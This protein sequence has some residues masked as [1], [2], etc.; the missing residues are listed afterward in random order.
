L[1]CSGKQPHSPG[2]LYFTSTHASRKPKTALKR[3]ATKAM[4]NVTS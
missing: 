4:E 3:Q 1:T 2:N